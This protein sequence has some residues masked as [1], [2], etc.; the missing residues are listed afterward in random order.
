MKTSNPQPTVET[1]ASLQGATGDELQGVAKAPKAKANGKSS[2][3]LPGVLTGESIARQQAAAIKLT[4]TQ[5]ARQL[6]AEAADG[7]TAAG[8]VTEAARQTAAR[9]GLLLASSFLSSRMD[10]DE[11]TSLLGENFGYRMKGDAKTRVNAGHE[12]ASKTPFGLGEEMRKRVLRLGKAAEYAREDGEDRFFA[13]DEAAKV[14]P[15][16][17][18][19]VLDVIERVETA[20]EKVAAKQEL[21]PKVDIGFWASYERFADIRKEANEGRETSP[22]FSIRAVNAIREGLAANVNAARDAINSDPALLA[23]YAALLD[24]LIIIDKPSTVN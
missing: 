15:L 2:A 12:K 8:E 22:A 21:D 16:D 1:N 17:K 19:K 5:T 13:G 9:A 6:L 24:V 7:M 3:P 10:R 18:S 14:P 11:L 23:T 20:A 4:E